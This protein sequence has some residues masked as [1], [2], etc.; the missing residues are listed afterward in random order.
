LSPQSAPDHATSPVTGV[1]L[2]VGITIVLAALLLIIC[3]GF[4]LPSGD[5]SA[6]AIFRI[7]L[8]RHTNPS[9]VLDYDSYMVVENSGNTAYDNRK[10][11]AKTYRNGE[12][13]PC[14]IPTLNGN[15][16]LPTHHY[17][18]QTLGGFGSHDYLWYPAATIAINYAKGTFHPGDVVQFE[19]YDRTTNNI[20]SR[21]T[22]PDAKKYDTK[23]FYNYFLNP[24]A[25]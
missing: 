4:Q 19:V 24:Q 8:I 22:Y 14:L 21:D 5:T 3:L 1:L 25:A 10:L 2:L 18:I 13:L 15:D 11:Y 17:G 23:W 20:I 9:G 6:P 7:T 16:F 12:L